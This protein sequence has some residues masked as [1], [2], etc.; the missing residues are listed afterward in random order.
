MNDNSLHKSA[1]V[2]FLFAEIE[3]ARAALASAQ[4]SGDSENIRRCHQLARR[5]EA[6]VLYYLSVIL[7]DAS[8]RQEIIKKV[9]E[10]RQ[11]RFEIREFLSSQPS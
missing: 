3:L 5:R 11:Q 7:I 4:R 2:A 8:D 1:E 9:D 6:T 10:L